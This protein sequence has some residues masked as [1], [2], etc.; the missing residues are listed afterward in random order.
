MVDYLK[1]QVFVRAAENLSFSEA[2]KTLHMTQPTISRQI[3]ALEDDLNVR[4]FERSTVGLRLT[5]A[6]RLL[7]PRARKLLC[8]TC[9]LKQVFQALEDQIVGEIRVACS[10]TAGKYVL[11]QVAARFCQRHPQVWVSILRCTAGYVV[12]QL[13]EAAAD[14]GV[15]SREI[16]APDLECQPFFVDSMVLIAPADHPWAK[17]SSIQ[18]ADLLKPPFLIREHSSGTRRVML[19]EL[20]KHDITLEDMNLFMELGSS[21]AIVR[22]VEAGYGVSFVSRLAADWALRQGAV[23]DVAVAGI[24]LSRSIYMV[25]KIICEPK[26]AV[27]ALWASVHNP[28]NADLLSLPVA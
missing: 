25:R 19:T 8:E 22:T 2:A 17:V 6:G 7:V 5:E 21:E 28:V 15:V 13:L 27:D 24:E 10:T 26:R 20:A 11:P 4:L 1:L 14:L 23:V 16:C 3:R 9:D 18:P 12:P